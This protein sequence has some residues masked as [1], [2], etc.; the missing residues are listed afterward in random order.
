MKSS[1]ISVNKSLDS[2]LDTDTTCL[3]HVLWLGGS[4][5]A[6]KSSIADILANQYSVKA[7]HVDEAFQKHSPHFTPD[8]YP[9]NY[10]WTHTPWKELWM[11]SQETL[12]KEAIDAYSEH[13]RFI[14]ADLRS[15]EGLVIAEGTS[16]LP[17]YIKPLMNDFSRAIWVVPDEDFQREKYPQRGQFVSYILDQCEDPE[18]ALQNWMDRD[19]TFARWVVERTELLQLRCIQVGEQRS[20][21]ENAAL[22][23][24]HFQL[25]MHHT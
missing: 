11:Q 13:L 4:P 7:Y 9:I 10:K 2:L 19:A 16:L 18:Q 12:L 20:I 23:A 5:C 3:E 24:S 17:D 25:N 22:V 15:V 14:F 21:E 1:S 6:G 8:I